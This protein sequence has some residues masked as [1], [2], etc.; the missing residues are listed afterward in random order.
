M[1]LLTLP[2]AWSPRLRHAHTCADQQIH[3]HADEWAA[4]GAQAW[5]MTNRTA[6]VPSRHR[7]DRRFAPRTHS[8]K[9]AAA[10]SIPLLALGV[11][12]VLE[13]VTGGTRSRRSA[14]DEL[15]EAAIGPSGLVTARRN[16][17]PAAV[18][19]VGQTGVVDMPVE[20]YEDT[21]AAT[22]RRSPTFEQ[23]ISS[24]AARSARR[25]ASRWNSS[26]RSSRSAPTSTPT[27]PRS[28]PARSTTTS[29]S[30]TR[31]PA[32]QRS[33]PALLRRHHAHLARHRRPELR[34]GTE[35]P[36]TATRQI[37]E[38][39]LLLNGAMGDATSEGGIDTTA[40]IAASSIR[41]HRLQNNADVLRNASGP[42]AAISAE[43]FPTELTD[44]VVTNV[45]EAVINNNLDLGAVFADVN[46]PKAEGYIAI[47]EAIA[48]EILDRADS[49][50]SAA[51]AR[52]RW[53]IALAVLVLG[54]AVVLT[55]LVSRS[56]TKPLRALTREAKEMAERRLPEAVIDILETPLGDDVVMPHVHSCGLQTATRCRRL[57]RAQPV[58]DTALDLPSIRRCC[59]APSPTASSTSAAA[60]RT[61]SPPARFITELETNETTPTPSPTSSADHLATRMRRN[62]ESLLVLAART[63]A[64][65]G[66]AGHADRRHPR[67]AR[68]GR[69]LPARHGPRVE[70]ATVLGSAAADLAHLLAE[71]IE[72]ALVFS[73]PDIRR[74]PRPQPHDS[75]G[76][77]RGH[78][79]RPV[80]LART[81]RAGYTLA[82]IDTASACPP[83]TSPPPT[84]ASPGRIVHD[85]PVKYLGHYV[86]GNLAARHKSRS[87][88]NSPCNG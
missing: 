82:I 88:W 25:T 56:I 57:G 12:T 35:L 48:A 20:G 16:D 4:D 69:G 83:A 67:R 49:L 75:Y 41:L 64:E 11:V 61:C 24:R 71:L 3:P 39:S 23:L 84:A 78:Q 15:A 5:M 42:Y 2:R 63:P 72:N 54:T 14:A 36:T 45:G 59:G 29:P 70:P 76:V 77:P 10:L 40:E 87:T 38:M 19:L 37:E 9:L 79:R 6:G 33:G 65:V 21:R 31:S 47:Q 53:F 27:S 58:Q 17:A 51:E 85:R 55:W 62:A 8:L 60:T 28:T 73:P 26:P 34:Q 43:H 80:R 30:A 32:L 7:K 13:V 44:R 66:R 22:T 46:V 74:H 18:D 86:A 1:V 68:R 50:N 81:P 52:Q